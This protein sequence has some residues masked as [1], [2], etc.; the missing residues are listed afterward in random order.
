[1][2]ATNE[3]DVRNEDTQEDTDDDEAEEEIET[4]KED[5]ID[6]EGNATEAIKQLQR[7]MSDIQQR[8]TDNE[9]DICGELKEHTQQKDKKKKSKFP[10]CAA[11]RGRFNATT[12]DFVSGIFNLFE[13][14]TNGAWKAEAKGFNTHDEAATH[15]EQHKA[16]I[17]QENDHF[18]SPDKTF[19]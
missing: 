1:M 15:C 18:Y 17:E 19:S 4:D 16:H 12:N 13:R 8:T 6:P 9:D 14:C 7:M 11:L 2:S 5:F 10:F 3:E